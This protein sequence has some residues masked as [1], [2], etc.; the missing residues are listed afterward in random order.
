[1]MKDELKGAT[2]D[3]FCGTGSKSYAY[4]ISD[5]DHTEKKNVREL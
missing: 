1:M 5:D 2:V 4:S 3:E